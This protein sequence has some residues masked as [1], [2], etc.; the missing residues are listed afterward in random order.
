MN[1]K[2]R[3]KLPG[4]LSY[5]TTY[6]EI[7]ALEFFHKLGGVE[8]G[9][10]SSANQALFT[11]LMIQKVENNLKIISDFEPKK[12]ILHL[13]DRKIWKAEAEVERESPKLHFNKGRSLPTKTEKQRC[14]LSQF[15]H[16]CCYLF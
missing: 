8:R 16:K 13:T 1:L 10:L 11:N 12:K 6:N 3:N 9:N 15:L 2:Y 5:I 4:M 14:R 7:F